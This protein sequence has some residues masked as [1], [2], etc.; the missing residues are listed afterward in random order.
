MKLSLPLLVLTIFTSSILC[1]TF[2]YWYDD[3][4]RYKD[5]IPYYFERILEDAVFWAER[6]ASRMASD[7]DTIQKHYF[8]HIF[9]NRN[10]SQ[11]QAKVQRVV[12]KY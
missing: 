1:R 11:Y 6:G 10:D 12:S 9:A 2:T 8:E 5:Q 7:V 3:S 4:C